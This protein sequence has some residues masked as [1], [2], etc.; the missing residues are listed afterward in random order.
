MLLRV[1]LLEIDMSFFP[2]S[3]PPPDFNYT[4]LTLKK[5]NYAPLSLR[6]VTDG[7][8]SNKFTFL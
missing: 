5:K 7:S 3:L 6:I 8:M 2:S 1:V 4:P